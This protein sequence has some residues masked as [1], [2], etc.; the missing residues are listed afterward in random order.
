MSL[1]H[2]RHR[3]LQQTLVDLGFSEMPR[4]RENITRVQVQAA[5]DIGGVNTR[6]LLDA[7]SE[8]EKY[9]FGP[10]QVS[11]CLLYAMFEEYSRLVGMHVVFSDVDLDSFRQRNHQILQSL[12]DVRDSLLHERYDNMGVQRQFVSSHLGDPVQLAIEGEQELLRYLKL[13]EERLRG[14][15]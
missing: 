5:N 2:D 11:L 14:G 3:Q 15:K 6:M 8:M 9:H 12:E 7:S 1:A 13:L 4:D 10:L